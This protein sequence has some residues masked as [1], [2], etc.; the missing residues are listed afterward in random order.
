MGEGVVSQL[1]QLVQLAHM[2][3][4]QLFRHEGLEYTMM[5]ADITGPDPHQWVIALVEYLDLL[6]TVLTEIGQGLPRDPDELLT[7]EQLA[8]LFQLSARTL[9]DQAGAGAIPHHRFG[10]H[11]RFSRDDIRQILH[12]HQHEPTR[13]YERPRIV[14]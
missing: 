14:A 8:E 11:Y 5:D 12:L 1:F 10:K 7:A 13:T 9:K 6:T 3:P 2:R 4:G